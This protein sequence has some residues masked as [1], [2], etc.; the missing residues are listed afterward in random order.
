MNSI[1]ELLGGKGINHK[2]FVISV[3]VSND[4]QPFIL[5]LNI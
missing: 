1:S 2:L 5:Q 4:E 3:N